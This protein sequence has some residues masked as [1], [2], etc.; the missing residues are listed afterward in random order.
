VCCHAFTYLKGGGLLHGLIGD[1]NNADQQQ[2]LQQTPSLEPA[3]Y[4]LALRRSSP[5]MGTLMT[6]NCQFGD[7]NAHGAT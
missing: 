5:I 3:I 2:A 4:Q 1:P 6:I 7:V